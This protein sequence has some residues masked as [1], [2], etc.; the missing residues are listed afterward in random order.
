MVTPTPWAT[1]TREVGRHD[2][3]R[4]ADSIGA[5]DPV[6]HDIEE[7]RRAGYPDLL[8]PEWFFSALGLSFGR[9]V[10]RDR[11]GPEGLP[12]D[13]DLAGRRVVAGE[14]RVEFYGD[15]V[16]GTTI[17]VA[18]RLVSVT[19]KE[20][21]KGVLE[22]YRYERTYADGDTVLVREFFSRIAR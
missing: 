10:T 12:L 3:R 4:F 21:S 17:T 2:V 1:E 5:R 20:G 7:A 16:A 13:D 22:V 6:H 15:I 19:R 14:T 9:W 8:A 11:L 18:Q